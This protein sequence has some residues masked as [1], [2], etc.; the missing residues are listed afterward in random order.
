VE[1]EKLKGR[2]WLVPTLMTGVE[3]QVNYEIH[4][5]ILEPQRGRRLT[6]NHADATKCCVQSAHQHRIPDGRYFLHVDVGQIHQLSSID[7]EW[8]YLATR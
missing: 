8:H 6:P 3:Y 2:G 4:F 1:L 5:S 7:Q